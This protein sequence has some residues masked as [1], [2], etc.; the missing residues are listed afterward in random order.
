MPLP[1]PF[2]QLLGPLGTPPNILLSSLAFSTRRTLLLVIKLRCQNLCFLDLR[3]HLAVPRRCAMKLF[4]P[5]TKTLGSQFVKAIYHLFLSMRT[6]ERLKMRENTVIC[7]ITNFI[8]HV[9]HNPPPII[10]YWNRHSH[11]PALDPVSG[12]VRRCRISFKA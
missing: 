12:P 8:L 6:V 7:W 5:K 1:N 10:C 2:I 4:S 3:T 11:S 9:R